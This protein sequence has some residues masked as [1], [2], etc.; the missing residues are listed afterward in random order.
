MKF[1][2]PFSCESKG[3]TEI[4]P[5]GPLKFRRFPCNPKA[6]TLLKA[7][8][9]KRPMRGRETRAADA[10]IEIKPRFGCESYLPPTVVAE[11]GLT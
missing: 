5:Q 8:Y 9:E 3:H 10:L 4:N 7:T 1:F 11:Q 2:L 6:P